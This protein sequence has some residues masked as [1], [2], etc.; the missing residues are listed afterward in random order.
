MELSYIVLLGLAVSFD[1]FFAGIAYGLKGICVP[2]RSLAAIGTIIFLY[3]GI[4]AFCSQFLSSTLSPG[5]AAS[6]GAWLLIGLGTAALIKQLYSARHAAVS[7]V[8]PAKKLTFSL[9]K[10]VISIMEKPECAD[11]DH[12]QRLNTLE[13]LLL[14][15]AL[16]L[17]NMAATFGAGLVETLPI[18]TPLIMC[19]IQT[20]L[21]YG[22][23]L[24]AQKIIP[25]GAKTSLAYLPGLV[26]ICIGI[27]RFL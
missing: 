25:Q 12:S 9:G 23:I 2:G 6:A 14:G 20:A 18:Y 3:T 21:I 15:T 26:L 24:A 7:P 5:L 1:G 11:M 16:G 27:A 10:I 4:A 13:A 22:G 19:A 17:D 8:C